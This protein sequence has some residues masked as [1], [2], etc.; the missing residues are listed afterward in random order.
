MKRVF[1]YAY[2]KINLGDDLFVSFITNRYPD[3][4]FYLWTEKQ[5]KETFQNLKNLKVIDKNSVIV[6]LLR[7][8]RAS[9]EARYKAWWE[10]RCNAS[11]YIGGSIFMEYRTWKNQITWL[12]Y[13]AEHYHFFVV[14]A[15]F[16][17]YKTEEY[18]RQLGT[19]FHKM[20][21]VCFR[22]IYSLKKFE[23][24]PKVRYAPDILFSY[25]MP[26]VA[27]KEKQL[28]VSVVSCCNKDKEHNLRNEESNYIENMSKILKEYL[29][30]GYH[31]VFSSFCREEGDEEEIRKIIDRLGHPNSK[32]IRMLNYDGT[33]RKQ[34]LYALAESEYIIGS[35]FHAIILAM[36]AGR[37]VLPIIYSDKTKNVLE[38]IGFKGVVFDLRSD[39]SWDYTQSR[40]NLDSV[41]FIVP[42]KIKKNSQDHFEKLDEFLGCK[43]NVKCG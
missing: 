13:Q 31:L 21:D 3:I 30:E 27:V 41:S 17:P 10:K 23:G 24:N 35:R 6:C 25:S 1:L 42:E 39:K 34:I 22:D 20:E 5:N 18:R 2:D 36:T 43:E 15:N 29:K 38:D 9:F 4:N 8:I 12:N 14:G 33:N 11:V 7:E 37:P 16:G 40:K 26:D 28:F 32:Q 19:V